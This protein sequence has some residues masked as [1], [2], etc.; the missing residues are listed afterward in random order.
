MRDWAHAAHWFPDVDAMIPN[1][2]VGVWTFGEHVTTLHGG[3]AT[4]YL[5]NAFDVGLSLTQFAASLR[6]LASEL[7]D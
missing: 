3:A 2:I 7:F 5:L 4:E 6:P 1:P